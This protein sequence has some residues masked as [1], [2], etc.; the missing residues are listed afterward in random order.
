MYHGYALMEHKENRPVAGSTEQYR[1]MSIHEIAPFYRSCLERGSDVR[2]GHR[3]MYPF[4]ETTIPPT[5]SF[6]QPSSSP[7]PLPYSTDAAPPSKKISDED[8]VKGNDSVMTVFGRRSS[9]GEGSTLA[10]FKTIGLSLS[11]VS[12]SPE[13]RSDRHG[14]HKPKRKLLKL[15]LAER[16]KRKLLE[17]LLFEN[18]VSTADRIYH[19]KETNSNTSIASSSFTLSSSSSLSSYSTT[20]TSVADGVILYLIRKRHKHGQTKGTTSSCSGATTSTTLTAAPSSSSD[21]QHSAL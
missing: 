16:T 10:S 18:S 4:K 21:F 3:S 15:L 11:D 2:V 7:S 9:I 13:S 8:S 6:S 14:K 17:R 1:E 20:S 5:T 12:L 19:G